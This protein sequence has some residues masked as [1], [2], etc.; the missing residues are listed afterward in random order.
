M[1]IDNRVHHPLYQF[2]RSMLNR[3][4]SQVPTVSRYY[5]DKGVKV[6]EQWRQDFWAFV[7]D[8][9]PR[10]T[11]RHSIDRINP[12]GDYEPGNCRWATPSEQAYNRRKYAK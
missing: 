4:R 7:N 10:P 5:A 1:L 11:L 12:N 3:T 6:C 2:W 9:G 8:M